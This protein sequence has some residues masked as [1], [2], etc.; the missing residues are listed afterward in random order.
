MS[1]YSFKI[2]N[3][4]IIHINKLN[5]TFTSVVSK[6][7]YAL[8]HLNS[9]IGFLSDLW[10]L[11]HLQVSKDFVSTW[12]PAGKF[13]GPR[14]RRVHCRGI[15]AQHFI[16]SSLSR[17]TEL[18]TR[19]TREEGRGVRQRGRRLT[20]SYGGQSFKWGEV[21]VMKLKRYHTTTVSSP[22]MRQT[23]SKLI[24]QNTKQWE[25]KKN[26]TQHRETNPCY[27]KV[28][29]SAEFLNTLQSRAHCFWVSSCQ[30][31]VTGKLFHSIHL[32]LT[33]ETHEQADFMCNV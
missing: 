9:P 13:K 3:H 23:K 5:K 32:L 12:R 17:S 18:Y 6:L 22:P 1:I 27:S 30:H 20:G 21:W 2:N 7:L 29:V 26:P 11:T 19:G 4:K 31:S 24:R 15:T 14:W 16:I 28:S 33:A 25:K 8:Y 10:P